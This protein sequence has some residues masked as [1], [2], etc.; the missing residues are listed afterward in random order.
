[1]D[2]GDTRG[3]GIDRDW[4]DINLPDGESPP[5]PTSTFSVRSHE[6][7]NPMKT[8]TISREEIGKYCGK[9]GRY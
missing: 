6:I 5:M 3:V 1:M 8:N 9:S 4:Y 2:A 7:P